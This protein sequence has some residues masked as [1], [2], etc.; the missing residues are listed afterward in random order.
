MTDADR[1]RLLGTYRTQR[2]RRGEVALVGLSAGRIP[3]PV[4]KRGSARA[5]AIFGG[6]AEAIRRESATAQT[7]SRWRAL[8]VG[9]EER[10]RHVAGH[11]RGSAAEQ[12]A[13]GDDA[14]ARRKM[15]AAH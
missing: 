12:A 8:G 13:A 7:V 15:S 9:A 5:L 4:G 11:R 6:L 3:W 14:P 2:F 1:F 10:E